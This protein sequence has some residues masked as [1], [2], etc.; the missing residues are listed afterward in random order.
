[1]KTPTRVLSTAL[2]IAAILPLLTMTGCLISSTSNVTHTGVSVS[3][4]SWAQIVPGKSADF[5]TAVLGEPTSKQKLDDGTE[6]WKWTYT[7]RTDSSG[8]VFLIFG[9][10][11]T[12]ENSHTAFV[13]LK[14]GVVTN[15]W[16]G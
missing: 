1:M 14:D 10:T 13:E 12:Q 11:S 15:H 8:A 4:A 5:V 3:D 16:R 9:G 2:T 7:E 6:I